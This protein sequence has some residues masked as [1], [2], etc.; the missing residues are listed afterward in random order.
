MKPGLARELTELGCVRLAR[1]W[2]RGRRRGDHLVNLDETAGAAHVIVDLTGL[3]S[4]VSLKVGI[5]DGL[6][7]RGWLG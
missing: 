7:N 6:R 5:A 3:N 1:S 4:H 2:R